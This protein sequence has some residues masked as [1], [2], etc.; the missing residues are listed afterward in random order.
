MVCFLGIG[1]PSRAAAADTDRVV[2]RNGDRIAGEVK[3]LRSGKLELST[4]AMGTIYVEW[5]KVV[6]LVS[7]SQFEIETTRG[8]RYLGSIRGGTPGVLTVA[9][10]AG[11]VDLDILSVVRIQP[12]KTG[13]LDRFDGLIDLGASYTK[14]SAIGQGWLNAEL[15][16]RRPKYQWTTTLNTTIT[17]QANEPETSRTVGSF[18]YVWFL[19]QRWYVPAAGT[20]ERNTDLGLDLRS[21]LLLGIGRY[22]V[23]TNRNTLGAAL[24]VVGNS[25]VP[26]DGEETKNV[27]MY[28]GANYSFFTY[29][30]PKT[31]ITVGFVVYPSLTVSKRVRSD[32]DI[33]LRREIVS[34]FTV[35]L[36]LY[37]T[38]DSKPPT[39]DA[40]KH[41][42]GGTVTVGWT[43]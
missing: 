30:T 18:E 26:S 12:I 17:V 7:P 6:E 8:T 38:Y 41:D 34:D 24:G 13:F 35:G 23:Q 33:T 37:D 14:S 36:T 15:R 11:T 5:D 10:A 19:P 4:T 20:F 21:S 22:F 43:F 3:G 16:S 40:N 39:A 25:E 32:T 9:L 31:T 1:A 2:L 29:D 42:Y 27:E 28:F